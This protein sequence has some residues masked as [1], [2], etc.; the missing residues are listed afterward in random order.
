MKLCEPYFATAILLASLSLQPAWCDENSQPKSTLGDGLILIAPM[1]ETEVYLINQYK[2]AV[3]QWECATAPGNATYLLD[4]GSLLRMGRTG[5]MVFNARGGAG[6]RIQKIGWNGELLWEYFVA[7]NSMMA[8]HDIAP[9]PNG[10]VLV[11]AWEYRSRE[12]AIEAGRN[13]ALLRDD[14]LWPETILEIEPQGKSEGKIVWQWRMWDHL[15]QSFDKS[16][17]HYGRFSEHPELIDIN[18]V[19]RR[20]NADWIH[21][22]SIDYNPKLDQIV[23]SAR[24]FDELWVIDHSTTTEEAAGHTGGRAGSGGDLIYR[25]GNPEAYFGGLVFDR[26]LFAQHDIHWIPEGLPGSGN[27]L[28]FN[29]GDR[30]GDRN[31]SSVDEIEPPIQ[32]DGSYRFDGDAFGPDKAVWS[33]SSSDDF[34]SPRISGAQRLAS[35]NTLICSGDQG[36]V[37]EVTPDGERVWEFRLRDLT[38]N[39]LGRPGMFRAPYYAA[40]H[41]ALK[42]LRRKPAADVVR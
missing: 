1:G 34:A 5:T 2:E 39:S 21:M 19:S 37:F 40:D 28:L 11:I 30:N 8:H 17:S 41:P 14:M 4:D 15:I 7:S 24:W 29:N 27:L 6:G 35:G 22:N 23:V 32:E 36:W 13:P 26:Q 3:H 10:N 33:Y 20:T 25:W 16:R 12:E 42:R 38:P 9:M 31:W 18:Y